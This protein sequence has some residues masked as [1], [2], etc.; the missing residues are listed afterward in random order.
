M[1]KQQVTASISASGSFV[2]STGNEVEATTIFVMFS[3]IRLLIAIQ[4]TNQGGIRSNNVG[5]EFLSFLKI[6]V[7]H[8][9]VFN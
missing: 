4:I 3:L 8:L 2:F 7:G 9:K 6:F 5:F 1:T